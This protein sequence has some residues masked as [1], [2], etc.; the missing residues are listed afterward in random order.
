MAVRQRLEC[1]QHE[2][3]NVN[4]QLEQQVHRL[5][6]VQ[7]S[8][9][10]SNDLGAKICLMRDM[11]KESDGALQ[12]MCRALAQERARR[13]QSAQRLGQQR[14]RTELLLELLQRFK[15]RSPGLMS[16]SVADGVGLEGA[17]HHFRGSRDDFN[18]P[19]SA[20]LAQ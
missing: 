9:R 20:T 8:S 4:A 13:E 3:D 7:G 14:A 5:Q 16:P 18:E 19:I 17:A 6:Y 1:L 2:M 15:S 11:L 12:Q 10:F